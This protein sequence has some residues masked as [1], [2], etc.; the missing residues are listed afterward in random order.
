MGI[1]PARGRSVADDNRIVLADRAI[2]GD[3]SCSS[4]QKSLRRHGQLDEAACEVEG[5]EGDRHAQCGMKMRKRSSKSERA[6]RLVVAV[7]RSARQAGKV[8]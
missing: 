8:R 1:R 2:R 4:Q 3:K 6:L 5:G 7:A